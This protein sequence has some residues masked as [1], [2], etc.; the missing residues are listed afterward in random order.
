MLR[1]GTSDVQEPIQVAPHGIDS[2][3]VKGMKAIYSPTNE[4][5]KNI[6]IGY[7]NA[8]MLAAVGETRVFATDADGDLKTFI[9]LKADGSMQLGGSADNAVRYSPLNDGLQD[10]K[11]AIN[12]ELVKVQTAIVSIG[13]AYSRVDV[14]VDITDSKIDEIKTL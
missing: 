2:N 9:W 7:M 10:L 13:G 4:R 3:P 14:S 11:T 8:D 6:I 12:A 5:G 1:F